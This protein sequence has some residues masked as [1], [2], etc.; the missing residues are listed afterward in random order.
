M[1]TS[2]PNGLSMAFDIQPKQL[3]YVL[4]LLERRQLVR[5]HVLNSAKTRCIVHLKRYAYKSES[6]LDKLCKYLLHKNPLPLPAPELRA[7]VSAKND[8]RISRLFSDVAGNVKRALDINEKQ[9]KNLIQGG[10]KQQMLCR[11]YEMPAATAQ[12]TSFD[13]MADDD[14][15]SNTKSSSVNKNTRKVRYVALTHL[16]LKLQ[17][18]NSSLAS[19]NGAENNVEE[20]EDDESAAANE[21]LCETIGSEQRLNMP[22][23]AQIF[24]KVE[25][26]GSEGM[27]IKRLSVLFGLDFYKSRRMCM[28]LQQHPEIVTLV[29]ETSACRTKYQAFVLRKFAPDAEKQTVVTNTSANNTSEIVL[30]GEPATSQSF[31]TCHVP[32]LV[33]ST[34]NKVFLTN[35]AQARQETVL[36]YL[37]QHR[38]CIRH[39]IAKEIKRVEHEQGLKGE[40]DSKTTKR[41]LLTLEQQNKLRLSTIAQKNATLMCVRAVDVDEHDLSFL[42]YCA[43]FRR[44]FDSAVDVKKEQAS[45]S[46]SPSKSPNKRATSPKK[47]AST[48]AQ[49]SSIDGNNRE[50]GAFLLTPAVVNAMVEKLKFSKRCARTYGLVPKVQKA[51]VLHRFLHHIMFFN[52]QQPLPDEQRVVMNV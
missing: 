44:A 26:C 28:R 7:L 37:A 47:K 8:A 20:D 17:L 1:F 18:D 32:S 39:E 49:Q 10:E 21:S 3:H 52:K 48:A 4:V 29:R 50:E 6:L 11:Y 30:D 24:A 14:D 34:P 23:F 9:L 12:S 22:L 15:D 46:M 31:E 35:R 25:Q 36:N 38:Y 13:E 41:I 51:I 27:P 43:Q 45:S 33:T 2:G 16:S 42:T 40:I 5:K 19:S